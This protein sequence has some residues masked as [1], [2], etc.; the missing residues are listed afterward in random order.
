MTKQRRLKNNT[1]AD[2]DMTPMLDIVF[3]LLIF[4]IVTTSFVKESGIEI[5]KPKANTTSNIDK[6]SMVIK[7]TD[8]GLIHFN[9]AIVDI[10]RVPSRIESFLANNDT[11]TVLLLPSKAVTYQTVVAVMDQIKSIP[12]L[13]IAIGK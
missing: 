8:E 5:T 12:E 4:F 9:N 3:I 2:V 10:E 13:T 1:N 7:I 6:P 11:N